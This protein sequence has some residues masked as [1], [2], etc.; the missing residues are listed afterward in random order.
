MKFKMQVTNGDGTWWE[1]YDK[2]IIDAHS[3]AERT[4]SEFNA[5]LHPK[6]RSRELLAVE[7]LDRQSQ[8]DHDWEKTTLTTISNGYHIY[9]KYRCR[10][11]GVTAKRYGLSES[12]VL[13][14]R[15]ARAEVYQRCDTASKHIQKRKSKA[16]AE[17]AESE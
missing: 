4:V 6:E 12:F 5:T 15:F 14:G 3:W 7:V 17:A 2:D 9:N 11:C 8:K 1:E 16:A 10:R 13:D